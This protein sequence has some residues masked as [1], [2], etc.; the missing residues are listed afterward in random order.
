MVAARP[1]ETSVTI[2]ESIQH[3]INTAARTQNLATLGFV[4]KRLFAN[5]IGLLSRKNYSPFTNLSLSLIYTFNC[6]LLSLPC[7]II[8]HQP[9]RF[10]PDREF[11]RLSC[12]RRIP[13]TICY[14]SSATDWHDM[15]RHL[16][17]SPLV[18]MR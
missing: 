10:D 7:L 2:C 1:L 14:K 3:N 6:F 8:Q 4:P 13:L 18:R 12:F 5:S 16:S 11:G 15:P 17:P 9:T